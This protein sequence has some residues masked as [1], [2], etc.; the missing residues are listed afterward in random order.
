MHKHAYTLMHTPEHIHMDAH[1][2]ALINMPDLTSP[3][4]TFVIMVLTA[5]EE[6]KKLES[7]L[8]LPE[9]HLNLHLHYQ[10]RKMKNVERQV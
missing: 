4:A 8:K 5:G 1:T 10:R 9:F 7:S 3:S 6:E 2:L